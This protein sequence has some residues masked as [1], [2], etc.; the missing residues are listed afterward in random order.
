VSLSNLGDRRGVPADRFMA[1]MLARARV[2][3]AP[4]THTSQWS[5]ESEP[6]AKHGCTREYSIESALSA[7]LHRWISAFVPAATT[8]NLVKCDSMLWSLSAGPSVDTPRRTVASSRLVK[9]AHM[10]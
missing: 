6:L 7:L 9:L 2:T 3:S 10:A 4:F 5:L 1:R 8:I